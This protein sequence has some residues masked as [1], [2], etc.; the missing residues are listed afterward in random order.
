[1]SSQPAVNPEPAITPATP[2][3]LIN[4]PVDDLRRGPATL[5]ERV[6]Q[7]RLG[8]A[9]RILE[10]GPEWSRIRLDHDGYTGWIHTR[11][12]HPCSAEAAAAWSAA[13][14][15]VIAAG[16]A[17]VLD[18]SGEP[19]QKL[20]FATRV[21]LAEIRGVHALVRIPDGRLWRVR[22]EDLLGRSA[23]PG[24]DAAGIALTLGLCQRF[25]GTPYLWGGRT[26]YGFDC[27][28]LAS[29][30]YGFMGLD[31]PRD[32]DQQYAAGEP[33]EGPLLAGDLVFFGEVPA[34]GAAVPDPRGYVR[35]A[36]ISHV[37]ISLGGHGFIHASGS[38][39]GIARATLDPDSP[40]REPWLTANYRGARRFRP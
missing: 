19:F 21:A 29:T 15:T 35:Q 23:A 33:V 25:L 3:A 22:S 13:C 1:M 16:F 14:D 4:R 38:N 40:L 7:A 5:T 37:G 34:D 10:S 2:W 26:P 24:V 31:I 20:V 32:S 9:A 28:G 8:E 30:F 17:E 18:D 36:H 39:W 11:A 12:L 6:S 27:S